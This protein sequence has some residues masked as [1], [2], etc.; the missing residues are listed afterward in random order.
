MAIQGNFRG[1][2]Q[3]SFQIG[4][5]GTTIY[6]K[7]DTP[8]SPAAGDLWIGSGVGEIKVYNANLTAW[9][10][11]SESFPTLNVDDGTLF[12]DSANDTVSIGSVA[13][14]EK[15]FVNGNLR[16]GVNPSFQHGGAYVDLRHSNGG[17]TN[18]RVR[19][20]TSNTDPIF[21]VYSASNSA[22]VFK[23]QGSTIRFH[24]A[25]TFPAA[26]G[27]NGQVLTT[28]GAGQASWATVSSSGTLTHFHSSFQTVTSGEA[29]TNASA[30]VDYTFSELSGAVHYVVFL[31]RTMLR[32]T[33]YSVSGTT[34]TI[35]IGVLATDDEIEVTG[36]S[37]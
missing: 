5:R 13:S 17:T 24:D 7:N 6:S 34:L 4:K 9:T 33:E 18:F 2:T 3:S 25:Y 14:N 27:T 20:N 12:V 15:L 32:P 16:L 11:I 8:D 29:S 10:G 37:N 1:T 35:S 22:Q 26:D 21:S 19:D 23:A 28:N 36:I 30:T 31:N